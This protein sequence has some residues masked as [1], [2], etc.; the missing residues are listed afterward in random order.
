MLDPSTRTAKVRLELAN[1]GGLMRAG[2]FATATFRSRTEQLRP[3]VP[4]TAILRLHD[5]DWVFVP[6]GGNHFRRLE[7]QARPGLFRWISGHPERPHRG[8]ESRR[9]RPAI[10]QCGGDGM[11]E[12]SD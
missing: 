1:P 7:V 3:M 2:M 11:K 8:R 4:T 10:R 5:K 12:L 6:L 9:Q